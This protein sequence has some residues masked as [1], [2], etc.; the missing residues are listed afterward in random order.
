MMTSPVSRRTNGAIERTLFGI[1]GLLKQTVESDTIAAKTGYLQGRDPRLKFL[2]VCLMLAA[3]LFSRNSL[4]IGALY[5]LTLA[6]ALASSIRLLFFLKRTLFFIPIFSLFIVVP[7]IFS[8][9]TPGRTLV[10]FH[11]L[12]F[13]FSI[14]WQG[15]DTALLFFL[16][17]LAS[18][19]LAILL[20]L[21]TRHNVLLKVLRIFRV[22]ALFVMTMGMCYRYIFLFLDIIQNNFIAVKSRVGYVASAKTGRKIATTN[23]AGLWLRSYRMQTQ[24]YSA[25]LSRCYGGEPQVFEEF[26]ARPGDYFMLTAALLMLI[27][28]V[29][30]NRFSH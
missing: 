22:P 14:S 10:A 25:M 20:M 30:L 29:W 6:I 21:T 23:M 19:S 9:V 11:F 18:V 5:A 1:V 7:A 26:H 4:E 27:G 8:A 17:V 24:V 15:V 2:S 3:I 28:T 16:R 13:D 12:S